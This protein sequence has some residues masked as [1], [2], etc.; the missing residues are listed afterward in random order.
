[1]KRRLLTLLACLG[2]LIGSMAVTATPAAA[3]GENCQDQTAQWYVMA[4]DNGNSNGGQY[5]R[6]GVRSTI[7][8]NDISNPLGWGPCLPDPYTQSIV[9]NGVFAWVELHPYSYGGPYGCTGGPESNCYIRLGVASCVKPDWNGVVCNSTASIDHPHLFASIDGCGTTQLIDLGA[10]SG[11][12]WDVALYF[13]GAAPGWIRLWY[14]GSVKYS[15]YQT[16]SRISCF[17][18]GNLK[19]GWDASAW[20]GGDGLGDNGGGDTP[21]FHLNIQYGLPGAGWHSPAY[22]SQPCP[23]NHGGT[24]FDCDVLAPDDVQF[25]NL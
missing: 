24:K 7:A 12:S 25:I 2:L 8:R 20:D 21:T 3:F 4:L 14:E 18:L 13:D 16:D 19:A 10:V 1:V 17:S 5:S 11:D 6:S 9:N 23:L 15:I 22:T